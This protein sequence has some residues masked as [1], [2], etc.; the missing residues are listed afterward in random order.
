VSI[1]H[2]QLIEAIA[3]E[4]AAFGPIPFAR[5]MELALYH[6]QFGYYT[7]PPESGTERIGWSGDF[8]TS[9][10]VHPILGQALAKQARQL[11]ALLGHPDP[12]TVVEMGPGKGLLAKH[13]LSACR[14]REQD[15]FSQRLRYV[16]I[17][18]SPAM[19][20]LQQANLL[21]GLVEPGRITWVESLDDVQP[22][23]VT[24]L[25]FS[26]ELPDAFPVHRIQI[27][28][29]Q[30]R[31]LYVDYDGARFIERLQ[32]PS[33]P[34]LQHYLAR[35]NLSL[36]DGYQTEINLDAV[37][38]M[39]QVARA[40][41]RGLAITIDYGHTAQDLYGPDRAKGTLLCYYSQMTNE[42]PYVR[43]GQQ[44]MTAHVDFSTLATVGEDHGLHVTGFTNQMSFLM[45]LGVEEM[46]AHMDPEGPEFR[47][48]IHLLRPEGMGRTFKVL[49]QHKGMAAPTLDGLAFKPFFGSALAMSQARGERHEAMDHDLASSHAPLTPS[50]RA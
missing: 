7:R 19:R 40:I 14:S 5:F 39:A 47:A 33:S 11:D 3:S 21:H 20:A 8:Y 32:P 23:S 18:R 16:L 25:F 10:D 38:W 13:F 50:L 41:D 30:I 9:S 2:P 37:R 45:G 34:D 12:F 42:E 48:A 28:Q 46:I 15:S 35:L 26:N 31:E 43:V 1:G 4:I 36:P 27:E 49:I 24:G 17:E 29:G 6:P 44:D 22:N